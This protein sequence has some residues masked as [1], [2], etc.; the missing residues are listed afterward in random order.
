MRVIA[1]DAVESYTGV[2][3]KRRVLCLTAADAVR[4]GLERDSLI[5][6][7][8]RNP[9]PLRAWV[10]IAEG[11]A[12]AVRLDAFARTVLAVADG[13]RVTL[14]LLAVPPL[15]NGMAEP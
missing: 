9:T 4:C 15:P 12:G 10:R 13:G 14:R 5:E 2:K 8:G 1:D 3:G 6:M 7:L 11:E